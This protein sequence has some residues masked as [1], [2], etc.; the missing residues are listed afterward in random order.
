MTPTGHQD[1]T[2]LPE[3]SNIPNSQYFK[4]SY[5][6]NELSSSDYFNRHGDFRSLRTTIPRSSLGIFGHLNSEN[7]DTPIHVGH[8]SR[9][10]FQ[11]T[12]PFNRRADRRA[13]VIQHELEEIQMIP[14]G[15]QLDEIVPISSNAARMALNNLKAIGKDWVRPFE[16]IKLHIAQSMNQLKLDL[17]SKLRNDPTFRA[18]EISRIGDAIDIAYEV[19]SMA[20][21][22]VLLTKDEILNQRYERD[23]EIRKSILTSGF[24]FLNKFFNEFNKIPL[25]EIHIALYESQFTRRYIF[26]TPQELLQSLLRS[27]RTQLSPFL[28]YGLLCQWNKSNP[29][30]ELIFEDLSIW[31]IFLEKINLKYAR[32]RPGPCKGRNPLKQPKTRNV[33]RHLIDSGESMIL[34]DVWLGN[35]IHEHFQIFKETTLDQFEIS[36]SSISSRCHGSKLDDLKAK[37]IHELSAIY[38]AFE[39]IEKGLIPAFF[40]ILEI[41][42][43]YQELE[44]MT[45]SILEHGTQ[46]LF[47]TLSNLTKVHF[48]HLY[49][50]LNEV[51]YHQRKRA[52]PYSSECGCL[53]GYLSS[54]SSMNLLPK[55]ILWSLIDSWLM[56]VMPIINKSAGTLKNKDPAGTLTKLKRKI[57]QAIS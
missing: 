19:L 50:P 16:D 9:S 10:E 36:M 43:K 34:S 20:F 28:I 39:R 1:H 41:F 25:D 27:K 52:S 24:E 38:K 7:P 12:Q 49:R 35:T 14:S 45:Q 21:C 54:T 18:T 53:I 33:E 48:N 46:F 56:K 40:R 31:P 26:Q 22:G 13:A 3:S 30:K 17:L 15:P 4:N 8:T 51:T 29:P 47:E 57:N 5:I 55:S 23:V 2:N 6:S 42:L 11:K 32:L 44:L 37:K